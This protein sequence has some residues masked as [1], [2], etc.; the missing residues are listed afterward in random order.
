MPPIRSDASRWQEKI[1]A[2]SRE[3]LGQILEELRPN[4]HPTLPDKGD[5]IESFMAVPAIAA[6]NTDLVGEVRKR[7][8]PETSAPYVFVSDSNGTFQGIVPV[9]KVFAAAPETPI[10]GQLETLASVHRDETVGNAIT[11]AMETGTSLLAVIDDADRL[12]GIVPAEI[13]LRLVRQNYGDALK[14]FTGIREN[15]EQALTAIEG[16][17]GRR[18]IHRLPWL[19]VGTFGCMIATLIMAGFEDVLQQNIEVAFF[20][21]GLVYLA[22]AIGTQSEAIAVRGL[23]FSRTPIKRLWWGELQTGLLLGLTLALL[24]FPFIWIAFSA[25]LAL[26]VAVALVFASSVA[27]SIGLLFPWLLARLGKDPAYGSG[28]IATIIQDLLSLIIYFLTVSALVF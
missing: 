17:P 28:P 5:R 14:R 3:I 23:T 8:T 18:V 10:D 25:A 2:W 26:A 16:R 19:L 11:V 21:P 6:Q 7:I 15:S 27:T 9:A 12:V 4:P 13:L 1:L 24:V 20:I 22:D